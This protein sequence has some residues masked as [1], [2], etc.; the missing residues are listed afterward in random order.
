MPQSLPYASSWLPIPRNPSLTRTFR[1]VSASKSSKSPVYAVVADSCTRRKSLHAQKNKFPTCDIRKVLS[2]DPSN[3]SDI[4]RRRF[5][6]ENDLPVSKPCAPT[7]APHRLRFHCCNSTRMCLCVRVW[8]A[9]A[10]AHALHAC[11]NSHF[12]LK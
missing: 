11:T 12:Q 1:D 5:F 2:L 8:R 6:Y 7:L 9:R 10:R 3:F 4:S